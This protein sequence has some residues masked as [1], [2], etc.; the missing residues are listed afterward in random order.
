MNT[1]TSSKPFTLIPRVLINPNEICK[2]DDTLLTVP[3]LNEKE[4]ILIESYRNTHLSGHIVI[5]PLDSVSN[6]S[7]KQAGFLTDLFYSSPEE[8]KLLIKEALMRS[9][10][11]GYRVAF[12]SIGDSIYL[13]SGFRKIA[14]KFTHSFNTNLPLLYSELVWNGIKLISDDLIFPKKNNTKP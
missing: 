2:I 13:K 3:H 6:P 7:D 5:K 8:G 9:W 10:E 4:I 1:I 12:T 14:R 11:L